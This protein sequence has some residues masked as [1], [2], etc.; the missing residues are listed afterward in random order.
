MS[1]SQIRSYFKRVL[2]AVPCNPVEDFQF[3]FIS[4]G[5]AGTHFRGTDTES[6]LPKHHDLAVFQKTNGIVE[7]TSNE[8][9]FD[10]HDVERF[11][12]VRGVR[13]NRAGPDC[14]PGVSS[15]AL[16]A[17]TSVQYLQASQQS[18]SLSQPLVMS[19]SEKVL[20]E[21]QYC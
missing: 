9:W 21:G 19:I 10:V 12:V 3:P 8:E 14:T 2:T 4:L 7:I 1:R 15:S 16:A 11:L 13:L 6:Q 20:I 5:G 18:Q 17:T